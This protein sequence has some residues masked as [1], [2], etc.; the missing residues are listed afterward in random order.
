MGAVLL[1]LKTTFDTIDHRVLLTKLSKCN[2]STQ[3]LNWFRSY[4]ADRKQCVV[5]GSVKPPYLDCPVVVTQG[6][7]L[8]PILFLFILTIFLMF[9]SCLSLNVKKSVYYF[10]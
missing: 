9:D 2:F 8:R 4:L 5:V 3:T 6:S 10:C 1:D 7:I